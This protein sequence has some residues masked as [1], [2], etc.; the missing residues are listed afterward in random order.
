MLLLLLGGSAG[1]L[2]LPSPWNEW[3][4]PG[5]AGLALAVALIGGGV[6]LRLGMAGA[7]LLLLIALYAWNPTHR[8]SEGLGL[9]PVD[10][11][12]GLPGSAYP[13]GSW[14]ALGLA[15]AMCVAF[16]LAFQLPGRQVGWL[17]VAVMLGAVAMA[18]V[19]IGQR[20]EPGHARIFP[21]TGVFVNENHFA[22]FINLALPLTLALASRSRF[23]A[24]Q[25]GRPS[26]PAGL[27]L[28]A[29][30]LMGAAVV[31]CRSRAGIAVMALLILAHGVVCLR[32]VRQY[33]FMGIPVSRGLR[34]LGGVVLLVVV[35][36]AVAAFAREWN[37]LE[38]IVREWNFR[39]GILKDT[40]RAWRETPLWGTG[41]GSFSTIFSYYQSELFQGRA[42]LHAHCEPVQFLSEFG[43][44][45]GAW[46][47]LAAGLALSAKG[48]PAVRPEPVP[49]FGALEQRAFALGL[50]AVLLHSLIDFPLRIPLLALM[51]AAW[52]GVW[53]G[54]CSRTRIAERAAA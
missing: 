24:I 34:M 10:A 32:L 30:A 21:Y 2:P 20:L 5:L 50:A 33:P 31:L 18:F 41:P 36:L 42:V 46:V 7:A 1:L 3:L 40:L 19:V 37:R 43:I 15:F 16:V 35:V 9:L 45:G 13:A 49:P 48:R 28:L 22:V 52:A 29:A 26:S 12:G 38:D 44:L 8:W 54:H 53:A 23:R 51:T 11:I 17:Q 25:E 39:S 27:Y 47:V 4:L 6:P 14:S